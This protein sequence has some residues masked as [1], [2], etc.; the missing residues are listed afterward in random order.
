MF[1]PVV[2]SNTGVAGSTGLAEL[3][4]NLL[5]THH[6]GT[7]PVATVVGLNLV[8]VTTFHDYEHVRHEPP[9][10]TS[11]WDKL[12][13]REL[14]AEAGSTRVRAHAVDS[15]RNFEQLWREFDAPAVLKPRR[16]ANGRAVAFVQTDEDVSEQ[17]RVREDWSNLVLETKIPATDREAGGAGCSRSR[18]SALRLRDTR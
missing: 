9:P 16:T 3:S 17:L 15:P 12:V 8:G 2:A 6:L 4:R 7:E 5:E 1:T 18:R 13:Q 14:L 10:T 11:V